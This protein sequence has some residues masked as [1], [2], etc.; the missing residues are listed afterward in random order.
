MQGP[1]V[2]ALPSALVSST[3]SS[4]VSSSW[5]LT[6]LAFS[7]TCITILCVSLRSRLQQDTRRRSTSVTNETRKKTDRDQGDPPSPSSDNQYTCYQRTDA[8]YPSRTI[9]Q[10]EKKRKKPSCAME[11]HE[12]MAC[13]LKMPGCGVAGNVEIRRVLSS[14]GLRF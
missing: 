4:G 5:L 8:F 13:A 11:N 3:L 12:G 6:A 14:N 9:E 2:A 7:Y 10:A 1:L